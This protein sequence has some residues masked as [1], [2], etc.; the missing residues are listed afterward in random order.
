MKKLLTL[1]FILSAA[2]CV[3]AQ[4]YK[5]ALNLEVG[6]EYIQKS[7]AEMTITQNFNGMPIEI[8]MVIKGDYVFKVMGAEKDQYDM[9]V[10]YTSVEMEME[11]AQ[12][13]STF[14]SKNPSE[15]DIMSTMLSRMVD[16]PFKMIMG[17]NGKVVDIKGIDNLFGSLFE[18]FDLTEQQKDQ[19]LAQLK[20]SYGAKAFK[21]SFEQIT[22]IYPEQ[23]VKLGKKWTT[24]TNI[25][26]GTSVHLTTNFELK[27]AN[28]EYFLIHGEGNMLSNPNSPFVKQNGMDMK[29]LLDGNLTSD[30]K[31]D[32]KTGWIIDATIVQ[33]LSGNTEL[34]ASEQMPEG[35]N[36]PMTVKSKSVI[37]N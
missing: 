27:A 33:N 22:A 26:A 16:K 2:L 8:G 31:V 5:L 19:I 21:G 32:R 30:I 20:K 35:M 18:G 17:Q 9:E 29:I 1:A 14:S 3:Q 24:E 10:K 25:E 28:T 4:K 37:T 34:K 12:G 36:I 13:K 11:S 7:N 6:K 23:K 15:Q